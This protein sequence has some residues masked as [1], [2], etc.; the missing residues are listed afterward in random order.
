[1]HFKITP[2]PLLN[3]VHSSALRIIRIMKK[4]KTHL[5]FLLFYFPGFTWGLL[6]DNFAS[7]S[8]HSFFNEDPST[9]NPRRMRIEKDTGREFYIMMPFPKYPDFCFFFFFFWHQN[10]EKFFFGL[11]KVHRDI[12]PLKRKVFGAKSFWQHRPF[13]IVQDP[14]SGHS[15]AVLENVLENQTP[16]P[17][18]IF[19]KIF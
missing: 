18:L 6:K 8:A 13:D 9:H 11:T 2:F 1:M 3:S 10:P 14:T 15:Q 16:P 17:H 4:K 19:L 12:S 5:L 7:K